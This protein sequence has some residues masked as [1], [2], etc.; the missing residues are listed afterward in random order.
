MLDVLLFEGSK[1]LFRM[2]LAV[3]KQMEQHLMA[4]DSAGVC[5]AWRLGSSNPP[6]PSLA[7]QLGGLHH[8]CSA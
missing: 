6:S 4:Y 7:K 8:Q 5:G 2:A 3:L 1:V